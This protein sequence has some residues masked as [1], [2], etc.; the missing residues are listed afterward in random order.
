MFHVSKILKEDIPALCIEES[1][2]MSLREPVEL[3]G[4]QQLL[5]LSLKFVIY[6]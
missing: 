4:S 2:S 6:Y 1:P 3:D 5:E